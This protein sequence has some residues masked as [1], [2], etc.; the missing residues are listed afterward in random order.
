[1]AVKQNGPLFK[2]YMR[3]ETPRMTHDTETEIEWGCSSFS[4]SLNE[5]TPQ[6][7]A[8]EQE[9]RRPTRSMGEGD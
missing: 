6:R 7:Q 5:T 1:M 8:L 4:A 9:M 2:Q 3:G